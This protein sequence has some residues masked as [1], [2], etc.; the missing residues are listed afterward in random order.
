VCELI[1]LW[2]LMEDGPLSTVSGAL[3]NQ[4][5]ET[6]FLDQR[7]VSDTNV[8]LSIG[9]S[10][11]G[12]ISVRGQM[13]DLTTVEAVY[14][15]TY[16]TRRLV[17]IASSGEG[18]PIWQHAMAVEDTLLSWLELV[19]AL[20][21]N[22]PSSMASNNSKPYQASYIA[23]CGFEIPDTLITTDPQTARSFWREHGK[24]IY[25]SI[26]GIR[27]IVSQLTAEH[28][29]RLENVAWCPTQFQEYVPGHDFRVHVVG[30][31]IF[32]CEIRSD[33]DDYRY[34]SRHGAS[35]EIRACSIPA[36]CAERCLAL[37]DT[38]GLHL[39]GIDLRRR[40]D[41]RWYC[42]EVNPSPGF[43]Y[44]QGHTGQPIDEAL[45]R[46]LARGTHQTVRQPDPTSQ[47][48][49]PSGKVRSVPRAKS[50]KEI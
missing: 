7:A 40:P 43:T 26:S 18:S 25:K 22:R 5:H 13:L 37:T 23:A 46:L 24:V 2:G 32:A 17:D 47:V 6:W 10:V 49:S 34:A 19:P 29:D 30:K 20:V 36:T 28:E 48:G 35:C 15:R 14:V 9:S 11:Q 41:G 33:A 42:F 38:L 45:V 1:M 50:R 4:G 3:A 16:D 8:E 12:S 39:A 44:Y 21:V 27:S 31:E